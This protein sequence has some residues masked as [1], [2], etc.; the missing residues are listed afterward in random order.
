MTAALIFDFDGTIVDTETALFQ[1]W[2]ER[3]NLSTD[4]STYTKMVQ[5]MAA[6]DY[7]ESIGG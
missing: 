6:L 7:I 3:H 5:V 2:C 1:A 4:V